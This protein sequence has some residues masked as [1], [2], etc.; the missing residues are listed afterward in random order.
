MAGASPVLM[1]TVEADFLRSLFFFFFFLLRFL[2][3]QELLAD[4][5]FRKG[6]HDEFHAERSVEFESEPGAAQDCRMASLAASDGQHA[7]QSLAG[8]LG[9]VQAEAPQN[10][11]Y[12]INV[13]RGPA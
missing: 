6:R 7:Q 10:K 12:E 2:E 1:F 4:L 3:H 11:V 5:K 13:F 8:G 9:T